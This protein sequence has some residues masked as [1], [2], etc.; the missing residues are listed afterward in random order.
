MKLNRT[1]FYERHLIC[2]YLITFY[3]IQIYKYAEV[4]ELFQLTDSGWFIFVY[5]WLVLYILTCTHT[6]IHTRTHTHAHNWSKVLVINFNRAFPYPY[7]FLIF[8]YI[9]LHALIVNIIR[10]AYQNVFI[11]YKKCFIPGVINDH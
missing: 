6:H 9:T 4:V 7:N 11:V 2:N 8:S 3:Y 5:V 10:V 1:R